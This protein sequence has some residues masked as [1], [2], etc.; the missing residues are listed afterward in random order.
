MPLP[1]NQP[2]TTAKTPNGKQV[3][4]VLIVENDASSRELLAR[5]LRLHECDADTAIGARQGL[6]LLRQRPPYDLLVTDLRMEPE[7]GVELL[8][9]VAE[10]DEPH[11]PRASVVLS[12]YL[13]DYYEKL[14][15]I[16]LPLELFQKPIHLPSLVS[17]LE[18]LRRNGNR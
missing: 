7:D 2:T 6:S 10:M 8:R 5:V 13:N 1:E 9:G 17:I 4:R 18:R 14:T 3:L 15:M 12:G 11:R 16:G